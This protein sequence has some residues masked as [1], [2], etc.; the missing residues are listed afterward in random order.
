MTTFKLYFHLVAFMKIMLYKLIYR[1]KLQLGSGFTFRKSFNIVIDTKQA[2]IKIGNNCFFNN[3]CTLAAR[4]SITIGEGSI[5]GENVKIYDHNHCFNNANLP[6]KD[7]GY[8][9]S[10]IAIGKHC[11]IASNVVILR[12]V[13]IGDRS[14]IGAGCI[15]CKD[16]PPNSILINEQQHTI[17]NKL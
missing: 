3:Y 5:F 10:P 1:Q 13:T 4:E 11:W 2:T 16:V 17:K 6:I 12:G 15:V 9:T 7:Q 14:V 8:K